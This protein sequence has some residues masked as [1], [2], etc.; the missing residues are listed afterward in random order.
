MTASA[1]G[2]RAVVIGA[3]VVGVNVGLALQARGF[4]VTIVDPLAPGTATSFGNAGCFATAEITPISMP[5][6]IWSVPGMLLDPLGP[7]SIRWR[8]L[9]TLAPWLWRFWLSGTAPQAERATSALASL[10]SRVWDDWTPLIEEANLA[11]LLRRRGGLFVYEAERGFA[12]ASHEWSLRIRHGVK[13]EQIGAA[14]IRE[15]EPALAPIYRKG[16]FVTDWGHTID[17]AGLV[18]RLADHFRQRGGEILTARAERI[19]FSEGRP[20]AIQLTPGTELG[21]ERLVVAAGAWSKQLC[22]EL[23]HNV[24]LETERG[25]NTTLSDPQVT[26]QRPV[27]C[28]EHSFVMTPMAMGLRIGGAVELAN[29]AAP[30]NFARARALLTLGRQALPGLN[31]QGGREWMGCRPSMPDSLPVIGRSPRYPN[32]LFAFGHGHLGL[33]QGATTGRLI[34]ELARGQPTAVNVAPFRIERFDDHDD[35]KLLRH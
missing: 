12:A 11:S 23:G 9:P 19:C 31:T 4:S 17:P 35:R 24:P 29:V 27:C 22:R 20:H 10:V 2:E 21:F 6:L 34:G 1:S 3:G 5:G 25:Y 30:P 8:S 33:T 26:L 28:A 15:L 7:L 32:V 16:Y 13:A 14:A 18:S